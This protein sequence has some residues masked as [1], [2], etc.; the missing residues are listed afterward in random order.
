MNCRFGH[1]RKYLASSN[2]F[3]DAVIGGW[4]LSAHRASQAEFLIPQSFQATQAN[5]GVGISA[6]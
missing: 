1:E 6:T 2:G 3:V 5:T 4:Q